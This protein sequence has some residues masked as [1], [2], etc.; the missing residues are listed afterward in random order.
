MIEND[1]LKDKIKLHQYIE[2]RILSDEKHYL[3]I[4]EV[5]EIPEWPEL[6]IH[7]KFL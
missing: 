7:L 3:F 2:K 6:S 4:D 1:E 5:Q